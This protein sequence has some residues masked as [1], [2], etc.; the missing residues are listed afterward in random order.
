MQPRALAAWPSPWGKQHSH[1]CDIDG[2]PACADIDG[3]PACVDT[4][5]VPTCTD[6]DCV[7]AC[8]YVVNLLRVGDGF[9]RYGTVTTP[10]THTLSTLSSYTLFSMSFV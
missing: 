8:T 4:D 6:L 5:G 2:V 9:C 7:P 1:V 10:Y 3:V